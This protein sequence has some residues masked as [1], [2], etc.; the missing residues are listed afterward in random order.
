MARKP[1]K[2]TAAPEGDQTETDAIK[3]AQDTTTEQVQ[4]EATADAGHDDGQTVT[5]EDSSDAAATAGLP[6]APSRAGIDDGQETA[7]ENDPA[8]M[9][10]CHRAGGRRRA[11]RRWPDGETPVHADELSAYELALLQGDPQFTVAVIE[12]G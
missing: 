2:P 6:A 7:P 3:V 12:R 11:G 4:A 10:I 1:A 8:F 5:S 9:V